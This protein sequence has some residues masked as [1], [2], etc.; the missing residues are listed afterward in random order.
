MKILYISYWSLSDPLTPAV[1]YPYFP[2]LH[3]KGAQITFYTFEVSRDKVKQAPVDFPYVEHRP[4]FPVSLGMGGLSKIELI[5]RGRQALIREA[6]RGGYDLVMAKA[7]MAG[8]LA[9]M[10]HTAT[11]LPYVVES[12]EPHSEYMVECGVW[13]RSGLRFRFAAHYEKLQVAHAKRIITVT[14]NHRHDLIAEGVDPSRVSVIPSITDL[15]RFAFDPAERARVRAALGIATDTITGIYVGKFGGLYYDQEAFVLFKRAME[16]FDGMRLIILSPMD[17]EWIM[18]RA[19][20]AGI[21]LDRVHVTSAR[22][23]DVPSYL[24]ASDIAFS[25]IKPAPV[26]L[27]QCPVKNGEYWANGLPMLMTDLVADDHRLLRQGIGGSVFSN[28]MGDV[29]PALDTIARILAD[30]DHRSSIAGLARKY[31]SLDLAREV[32][33]TLF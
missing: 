15:K 9:H 32:Y 27:Y 28:D 19:R 22:H 26:K 30:P 4:I 17:K 21:P 18:G 8:A 25:P 5:L 6:R 7:A 1:I 24:S 14:H 31:K 29:G 11:G 3:D 23:D 10:V 16:R 2:L 12:F 13:R 20:Q 33:A